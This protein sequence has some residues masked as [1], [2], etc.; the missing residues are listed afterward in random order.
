MKVSIIMP[1]YNSEKYIR[2]AIN[3]ILKQNFQDFE[4]I[5]V[6]DASIDNTLKIAKEFA[7][8]DKRIK[9]FSHKKNKKRAGALNTG[10]KKAK[11]KYISFLDVDDIYFPEKTRKQVEF[12]DENKDIDL[13]YGNFIYWEEEREEERD[14][15]SDKNLLENLKKARKRKDLGGIKPYL[16]L[17]DGEEVILPGCSVMIKKEVMRKF[18]FDEK[19]QRSQDYDMWFQMLGKGVRFKKL[20]FL[21]YKWRKYTGQNSKDKSKMLMAA[22][23]INE[24][25]KK[26][27]YFR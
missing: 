10:I 2:E 6:N 16:L 19:L 8:K 1:A 23:Q 4:L 5:I 17:S 9:V 13:V 21:T 15:I 12:L 26:G 27:V 3:S 24:K 25:L 7:K 11:G 22:R 18:R 14:A 20:P